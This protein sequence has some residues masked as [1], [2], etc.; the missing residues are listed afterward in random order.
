MLTWTNLGSFAPGQF[1][2]FLVSFTVTNYRA[3]LTNSATAASAGGATNASSAVLA[4]TRGA[5]TITKTVI[6]PTNNAT[7]DHR[8][9]R[10]VPHHH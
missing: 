6:S 5:L 1:T 4:V 3:W 9:Q 2:N 10:R 7:V 8:Q